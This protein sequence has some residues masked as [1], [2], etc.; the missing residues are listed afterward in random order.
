MWAVHG[1]NGLHHCPKQVVR[2]FDGSARYSKVTQFLPSSRLPDCR[3]PH[4]RHGDST[5]RVTVV[6]G[7]SLRRCKFPRASISAV[8][9]G[10]NDL[11]RSTDD[12]GSSPYGVEGEAAGEFRVQ[13]RSSK[14]P[15]ARYEF[16]ICCVV[17]VV[18]LRNCFRRRTDDERYLLIGMEG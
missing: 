10:R 12:N 14:E 9:A 11:G 1:A 15:V 17:T 18:S 2:V 13:T 3:L 7:K 8:K 5:L 4:R 6:I 16:H